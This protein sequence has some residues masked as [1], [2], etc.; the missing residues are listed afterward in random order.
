MGLEEEIKKN[1]ILVGLKDYTSF[2]KICSIDVHLYCGKDRE[3]I[4]ENAKRNI[5]ELRKFDKIQD[6]VQFPSEIWNE[7]SFPDVIL[8]KQKDGLPKNGVNID[9]I[10]IERE[11]F[12]D[13]EVFSNIIRLE[14]RSDFD[15]ERVEF[16]VS[17]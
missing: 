12:S 17:S 4:I 5:E 9:E 3:A 1:C 2:D 8:P 15:S 11:K 6:E 13:I 10:I 7:I 16:F 14:S